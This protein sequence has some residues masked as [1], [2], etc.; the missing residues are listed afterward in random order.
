MADIQTLRD[1]IVVRLC[2]RH[3]WIA[4]KVEAVSY[5]FGELQ[6][7][8]EIELVA[9]LCDRFEIINEDERYRLKQLI[10]K[11]IVSSTPTLEKTLFVAMTADRD[12]DSGQA[13]L[14]EMKATMIEE[15]GIAI[16]TLNSFVRIASGGY[17]KFQRY[18]IVDEFAGSGK[19]IKGRIRDFKKYYPDNSRELLIVVL[20]G[21]DYALKA[22]ENETGVR[23][24]CPKRLKRGI[25]D[26]YKS[27]S[28]LENDN[29]M[30]GIEKLNFGNWRVEDF[31][32][33][34]SLGYGQAQAIFAFKYG[35]IPNNVF[36]IF[37]WPYSA[38][39]GIWG[40]KHIFSRYEKDFQKIQG[41]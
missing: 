4:G 38:D 1:I 10:A 21:M 15:H 19:T 28:L 40:R 33:R 13:F 12:A 20:A 25:R 6:S 39:G 22:I 2:E 17:K 35:H 24:I 5:M 14:Q 26:Y 16:K 34:F 32:T 7:E 9:S 37:W 8:K 31:E 18:I 27:Y 30:R 41:E 23:I 36:P 3:D 29:L 11:E